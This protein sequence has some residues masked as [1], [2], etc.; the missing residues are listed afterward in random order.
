MRFITFIAM[1]ALA[2]LLAGAKGFEVKSKQDIVNSKAVGK[3]VPEIAKLVDKF[4]IKKYGDRIQLTTFDN[5]TFKE[6]IALL[7]KTSM[8]KPVLFRKNDLGELKI[9]LTNDNIQDDQHRDIFYYYDGGRPYKG[10]IYLF[11]GWWRAI[12]MDSFSMFIIEDT[13]ADLFISVTEYCY[14]NTEVHKLNSE[15][16]Y[17]SI[18]SMIDSRKGTGSIK[19]DGSTPDTIMSEFDE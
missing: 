14:A 7:K 11:D 8:N 9:E 17:M 3:A 19:G 15:D 4:E 16:G 1:A 13:D 6:A 12:E 10:I 5:I 18:M 2:V